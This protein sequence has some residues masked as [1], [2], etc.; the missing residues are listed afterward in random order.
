MAHYPT[1]KSF[2]SLLRDKPKHSGKLLSHGLSP[3]KGGAGR[4]NIG[5]PGD[6][7]NQPAL[8]HDDPNYA[9]DDGQD[10]DEAA[11]YLLPSSSHLQPSPSSVQSFSSSIAA[12][13]RFKAAVK[14]AAKEYAASLDELEFVAAV[15][16]LQ[17]PL[18]QQD[19][20]YI[21]MKLSF[22]LTPSDRHALSSLLLH[23]FKHTPAL[24]TPQHVAHSVTKLCY[25]L[26]DLLL[27]VPN[28]RCY[29]REFARF[30]VA[31]GMLQAQ[32]W[33]E[34]ERYEAMLG[35]EGKVQQLKSKIETIVAELLSTEEVD[36]AIQS[37]QDLQSP[38][39][40]TEV[41]KALLR[42]ALDRGNR[43]RELASRFLCF[44]SGTLF[45]APAVEQAV[46]TLLQRVED[47]ALDVPDVLHLLSVFIARA[48]VDECLQPSFLSRV[49]V[50][51]KDLGA[52]VLAQAEKLLQAEGRV[53][54]LERCWRGDSDARRS[55]SASGSAHSSAGGSPQHSSPRAK[56]GDESKEFS[57]SSRDPPVEESKH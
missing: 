26:P 53:E 51:Q 10:D 14:S 16:E 21:L 34:C 22:D 33:E 50:D 37:I 23:L 5:R 45:S 54:R 20:P 41:V 36:D 8:H 2:K 18:F 55:T 13:A 9:P 46:S 25:A 15:S 27:D 30:F 6:E 52:M 47:L 4:G 17:L 43:Q 32:V 39:L 24:I 40:H 56:G 19:V 44:T 29:L 7:L 31:A 3:R 28:A 42:S 35:E 57:S 12:Y 38:Q 11:L 49:D 48:V 1:R